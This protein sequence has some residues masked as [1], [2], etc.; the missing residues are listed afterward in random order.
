[1]AFVPGIVILY[2]GWRDPFGM[3]IGLS[4][5]IIGAA[6]VL[7]GLAVSTAINCVFRSALYLFAS[8]GGVISGFDPTMLEAA[9][10]KLPA[11]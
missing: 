9:L 6:M 11:S 1:M 7:F 4:A 2:E 10:R 5:T 8:D 3:T